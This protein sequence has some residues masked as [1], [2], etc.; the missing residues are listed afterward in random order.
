M[1]AT[2]AEALELLRTEGTRLRELVQIPNG[3]DWQTSLEQLVDAIE[4]MSDEDLAVLLMV[5]CMALLQI[6]DQIEPAGSS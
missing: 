3:P 6:V 5:A 4:A 1:T 2:P